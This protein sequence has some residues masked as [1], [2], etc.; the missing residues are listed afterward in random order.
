LSRGNSQ[1]F[2]FKKKSYKKAKTLQAYRSV[3]SA[4]LRTDKADKSG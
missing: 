3:S 1:L 4:L 2:F